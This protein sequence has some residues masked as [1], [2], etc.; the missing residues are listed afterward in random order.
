LAVQSAYKIHIQGLVQGVGFRPFIYRLA[1]HHRLSGWVVN[2]NDGVVVKV[3]AGE[4]E[5]RDFIS[6]IRA[7]APGT[8]RITSIH[9]QE[10]EAEDLSGFQI[11]SSQDASRGVT[12]ISPDIAVCEHCLEDMR[13]QPHRINY[14]FINCTHCGPRFSIVRDLPYDRVNTTMAGF[15]MCARCKEEYHDVDDRRF[16]AQPIACNQCGPRY[17][18]Y[19]QGRLIRDMQRMME[20]V[21]KALEKGRIVALK[22]IGGFHLMCDATNE[23]SVA[24]LRRIKRRDARPLACMFADMETLKHYAH[25][26]EPEQKSLSSW[27][28]PIVLLEKK[29]DLAPSVTLQLNTLGAM[30]PYMPLHHMLFQEINLPALVMTSANISD[31]PLIV[32]N[33][34]VHEKFGDAVDAFVFHNRPIHNRVDDSVVRVIN[35]IERPIRRSRGYAPEPIDTGLEVDGILATGGELKNVFCLG[36]DQQAI[37]SQHIGDL[38][39]HE[40]YEFY[41]NTIRQFLHLFRVEPRVV[42]SDMHPDY[43]STRFARSFAGQYNRTTKARRNGHV[44]QLQVQH[45]HAHIAS[46]MSEH[47]LDEKVIGIALDGSGY[48][49]DGRVW[50]GEFLVCDLS[51]YERYTHLQ[52]TP[53]PGGDKV[54]GEPWRM[55]VSYLYQA[56]GEG[57]YDLDLDFMDDMAQEDIK[58]LVSM[59]RK[60][61]RSPVTSSTG[62]LF[63]AVAA[64]LNVCTRARFEAE[65]AMRLESITREDEDASY[66]FELTPDGI[67][68][69]P[70]VREMVGEL[71]DGVSPAVIATRF[72]NTLALACVAVVREIHDQTGLTKVVLSGGTFQNRYLSEALEGMLKEGAFEV[73]RHTRVPANDGGLALGQ[74]A[75]ASKMIH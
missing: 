17:E 57:L 11:V 52:Y 15:N 3:M 55:A 21:G 8:S 36:K 67:R 54:T 73:Y 22:G 50:G 43:R 20:E 34:V 68:F 1:N 9:W 44:Q 14:P 75:I 10:S 28:R 35:E 63:D 24:R 27:R 74:L 31:E 65:A 51:G 45:H 29:K 32:Q 59:V 39:N 18:Y 46:C 42:V 40:V 4:Q 48:G 23:K 66:T 12:Q 56:Y 62:R 2:R 72:H 41:M 64:L 19:Q 5:V 25:L 26:E 47:G 71:Q 60:G 38:Q 30:L 58:L 49:D 37:M 70:M 69:V 6:R 7:Q 13:R 61:I 53:M 16:H 33:Q